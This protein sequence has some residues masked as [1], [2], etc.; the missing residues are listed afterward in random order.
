MKIRISLFSFFAAMEKTD[1]TSKTPGR[2]MTTPHGYVAYIPNPL[3]P[4]LNWPTSLLSTLSKADRKLA[5]LAEIGNAFPVPQLVVRPFIRKEAVISSQI[6]GTHTSFEELLSY[7]AGQRHP[8]RDLEDAKEVQNYVRAVDYGLNRM[9]DLPLSN[10]LIREIHA[11][12]ME[13]VR[14]KYLTPGEFRR[15]QNWI[16]RPGVS[17][18]NARYVP[19]PVPEMYEALND[20]ERFIHWDPDLP[21]LVRIGLIHYQFE[22][23]HPF[24]DG[25]GRIGRLLISLLLVALDLLPLPLLNLSDYFDNHRQEYY[26]RL[27]NVTQKG[28]WVAWMDF[29]LIGVSLQAEDT[30]IRIARLS[31]LREVYQQ[32]FA[33]ERTRQKLADLVDYLIGTPITSIRQVQENLKIGSYTTVQRQI[34]I[35]ESMGIV[36]E[37]TGQHR[38]RLYQADEIIRILN[39]AP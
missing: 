11:R 18:Q 1:F 33:A 19:P 23:I 27:M 16:G 10:R 39:S 26:D 32:R 35:L 4:R 2:V 38:N 20:L 21:P 36:R 17:L 29:F 5:Y 30:A 12:L 28:A 34:E 7:E 14:G 3:P 9:A 8:Q 31:T 37:I 24:L 13:G 25:N 15:S 6:E 22:A